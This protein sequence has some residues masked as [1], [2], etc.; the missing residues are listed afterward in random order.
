MA[1]E[2]HGSE[3]CVSAFDSAVWTERERA[4]YQCVMCNNLPVKGSHLQLGAPPQ[5]GVSIWNI[6]YWCLGRWLCRQAARGQWCELI[7][8]SQAKTQEHEEHM[9]GGQIKFGMGLARVFILTSYV[10]HHAQT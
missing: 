1:V 8:A 6:R 5:G 10:M 2:K 4:A 3:L 9:G 7:A